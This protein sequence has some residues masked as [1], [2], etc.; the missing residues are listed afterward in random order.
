ML[1][2]HQIKISNNLCSYFVK[3]PFGNYLVFADKLISLS[4]ADE[5]L[6][7]LYGGVS[8]TLLE[9]TENINDFHGHIFNRYG[10][11]ALCDIEIESFHPKI[12]IERLKDHP[13][14]DI[15]FIFRGEKKLIVFKQKD[16]NI[17]IMGKSF[18]L[19]KDNTVIFNG[20]DHLNYVLDLKNKYGVDLI[21]FTH[22]ESMPVMGFK[23]PSILSKIHKLLDKFML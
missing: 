15:D 4:H 22:F 13:D 8:K 5:N 21:Y 16:K 11:S 19:T 20:V 17:M 3:R 18:Y 1:G 7:E 23:K 9:S 2:I 14:P 10:S 12:K 6:F